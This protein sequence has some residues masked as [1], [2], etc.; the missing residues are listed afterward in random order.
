MKM[1]ALNRSVTFDYEI[2][3]SLEAGLVLEGWEVKSIIAGKASINEAYVK[4]INNEIFLIGCTTTPVGA[5]SKFAN[6]EKNR[7]KK[8]LLKR[9][10]I[11]RL[12]GKVQIAGFTL[13]PVKLYYKDKRIKLEIALAKGKKLHDKRNDLKMRDAN[14]AIDNEMKQSK[15]KNI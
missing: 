4:I 13:V 9:S 5:L 2:E 11:D 12:N 6:D 14:R 15:N 10:E 8:L 3:T 7:T 1:L